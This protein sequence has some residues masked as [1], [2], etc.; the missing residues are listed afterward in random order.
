MRISNEY[1]T[2]CFESTGAQ[3]TSFKKN[4]CEIE[5][6]W[7]GDEK[8]WK[9]KNPI[10][11]PIVGNTYTKN[12]QIDGITYAMGNHGLV[13]NKEFEVVSHSANE[14]IFKTTSNQETL[15]QYPF[16]WEL[17]VVYHL[18]GTKLN[19]DYVITNN[20]QKTM[21]FTFGLHPAFNCP[22]TD[23]KFNDY[24]IIFEK[25]EAPISIYTDDSRVQEEAFQE[26]NLDYNVFKE[27]PTIIYQGLKSDYL[28]LTNGEN[29]LKIGIKNYPYLAFWCGESA[30]FICVEPWY[31]LGDFVKNE[32]AFE[33]RLGM[34]RLESGQRFLS[35]YFI[36]LL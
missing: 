34:M 15:K 10:L 33:D 30:P 29:G 18:D 20:N 22:L 11:F 4:A 14:I 27:R 3:I 12:Y 7:Q 8:Y 5:Y 28:T 23:D 31:G 1:V 13:R 19:I 21:P 17:E 36:E 32:V 2:V 6:M 25:E 9:G 24:K 26:F 35:N 16:N